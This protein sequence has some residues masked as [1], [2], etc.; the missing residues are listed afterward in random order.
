MN[1][2]LKK[3]IAVASAVTM[4]GATAGSLAACNRE[5]EIPDYDYKQG[6]INTYTVTVPS[7]WNELSSMDNNN[8]QIMDYLSSAFYEFDYKFDEAKGGKFN[9]DGSINAA[10]IVDGAF[11][12]RYSAATKLE[13]VTSVVDAKWGYTDEQKEAGNYA[14]KITLRDDLKWDDGTPIDA[15]DFVYSMKQQLD[16]QFM[17]ER[18]NSYYGAVSIKGTKNYVY[19]GQKNWYAGEV[20]YDLSEYTTELDSKLVFSLGDAADNADKG[21]AIS[22]VRS[23]INNNYGGAGVALDRIAN[24]LAT[25]FVD[26]TAAEIVSLEGKTLAEIKADATLK[27]IWED[28]LAFWQTDPGEELHFMITE[29][30]WPEFN[31]DNVGVY[32]PSKY[33]IVV[34]FTS[35]EKFLKDDGSLSYLAGYEMSSLPLV[36]KDLYESCKV[37]PGSGETLYTSTYN[38][39]LETTASWGPYKLTQYQ[40]G[41]SYTLERNENWYGYG[42]QDNKN[43]YNIPK[44]VCKKIAD[45]N[46]QWMSFL[47]GQIDSIGIDVDHAGDYRDSKYAYFTPGTYTFSLHLF[48][49]LDVLKQSGRNNGIIAIKDFRK[50]LSL[51]TDRDLYAAANTTAYRGA[52]GYLNSMYYYDV[53]N[54]LVYRNT[55]QGKETLLNAYG[56][57]KET[58]GTWSLS[59]SAGRIDHW[60]LDDAYESLKG[61]DLTLAKEYLLAAYEELTANAEKYGYDATKNIEIKFGTSA[62]NDS[63]RREFKHVQEKIIDPLV[64]G[65]PLEGKVKLVF[66][67]SFG[68]KWSDEFMAGSYELCTSAWGSAAFNPFYFIGAY[69]DP[70]NAYTAKYYDTEKEEMTFKMPGTAGE[71]Q[72]AGEELTMT[73]MNWYRCLNGYE[74]DDADKYKYDWGTGMIKDEY[75]LEVLAALEAHILNQ[76]Y[77]IP[78]ITQ[79]SA[80]LVSPKFSYI[81]DEYNTFVGYGGLRYRIVNYTDEEWAQYVADHN[82]DLTAEYKKTAE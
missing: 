37:A 17:Y 65:T 67:A 41:D 80:T 25:N 66:D 31:F 28:V 19:Q 62:D 76:Y 57:T 4:L 58:D 13:D 33:E 69:I 50:A 40:A 68:N 52:Y 23:W 32:S 72:G 26:R 56:Y 73:L 5:K 71:F 47:S 46:T 18:S 54:G 6:T 27:A 48:S 14:W 70:E 34:C 61:Y 30:E 44:I 38:T 16:P 60:S 75:R 35:A 63:T 8:G 24:F 49:D 2:G 74:F 21:K 43:Q 7:E 20:A 81:S 78:T 39:S 11:D 82:N 12:M 10:A 9:K 29:Y 42:L 15:T 22:N 36:K 77:S 55:V 64:A 45:T 59:S 3:I 1:K 51:A 53:E 79:N